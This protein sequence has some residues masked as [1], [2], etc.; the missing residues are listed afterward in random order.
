MNRAEYHQLAVRVFAET[1]RIIPSVA[2][3]LDDEIA[4]LAQYCPE[5]GQLPSPR[6]VRTSLVWRKLQERAEVDPF[7]LVGGFVASQE[8]KWFELS[9]S[10]AGDP[11]VRRFLLDP[12]PVGIVAPAILIEP[13][14]P[15]Q[16]LYR[17]VGG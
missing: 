1:I 4:R 10:D 14:S 5:D 9:Y 6:I 7:R 3:E 12:S 11:L 17:R 15:F 2:D 13:D 16:L 8:H